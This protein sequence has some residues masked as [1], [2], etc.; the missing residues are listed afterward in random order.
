MR[1]SAAPRLVI[2]ALIAGLL[3]SPLL[4]DACMFSCHGS[5]DA[6]TE[7]SEPACHHG[8]DEAYVR[9]NAPATPCGHDHTPIPTTM[10]ARERGADG[11][12]DL[13]FGIWDSLEAR[14]LPNVESLVPN[15]IAPATRVAAGA[16]TP[17]RV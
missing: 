7:R 11:R 2:A 3:G 6:A 10:T 16:P 15:P 8:G 9:V 12:C 13:V 14:H 17:L 5:I 4:L 1:M